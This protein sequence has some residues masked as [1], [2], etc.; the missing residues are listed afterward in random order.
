[1]ALEIY[2]KYGNQRIGMNTINGEFIIDPRPNTSNVALLNAEVAMDIAGEE[3]AS[4][5]VRGTFVATLIPQFTIDG[6]N[7]IT[8]PIFNRPLETFQQGITSVGGY[9]FEIPTGAKRVRLLCTSYG[10]GTAIVALTANVGNGIVYARHIPSTLHATVTAA[11]GVAATL[12]LPAVSGLFH[13]ITNIKIEK[14]AAALLT[15]AATPVLVTTTNMPGSRVYT[16][17]ASAQAQGTTIKEREDATTPVKSSAA[18]TAT[19][20]IAPATP[21]VIWRLSVDYYLGL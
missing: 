13:Y 21:N 20:F 7:W 2:D 5:D 10:S 8:V 11:A 1:M 14:F 12:T 19:T 3:F 9:Q 15:A 17:D 18:G 4:V 6:T 16:I